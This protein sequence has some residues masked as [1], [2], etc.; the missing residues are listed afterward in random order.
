MEFGIQLYTLRNELEKDYIG[1]LKKVAK[2]GYKNVEIAG[3]DAMKSKDLRE[4]LEDLG[5]KA[6]SSHIG[7]EILEDKLDWVME[8]SQEIGCKNIIC[9]WYK[10]ENYEEYMKLSEK[11]NHIGELCYSNNI[12][13]GYHNH[14]HEFNIYNGKMGLDIILDNTDPRFV[15]SELDTYWVQF[16]GKD[17]VGTIKKYSNRIP[18]IHLKDMEKSE[19]RFFTEVGNGV[20]DFK[21]IINAGKENGCKQFIVEQD[22][23]RKDPIESITISYNNLLKM[24]L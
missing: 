20:M 12:Q 17:V 22:V 9:P 6:P 14:D 13:F 21:A 23:C 18:L 24:G 7:L 19:E 8:Y 3:F 5:L 1:T 4:A 15:K 2:I 11:L 16:A 10:P